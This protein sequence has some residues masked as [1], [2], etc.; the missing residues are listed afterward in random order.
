MVLM[1][2]FFN[3]SFYGLWMRQFNRESSL[4]KSK[5]YRCFMM[6]GVML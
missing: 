1:L 4:R 5:R 3:L 2:G 6:E